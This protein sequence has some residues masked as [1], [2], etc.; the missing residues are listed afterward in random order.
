MHRRGLAPPY[1][2]AALH[3][4]LLPIA[5]NG[6]AEPIAP[7]PAIV[8][9][10]Q[11]APLLRTRTLTG[12]RS[13]K[14]RQMRVKVPVSP[15]TISLEDRGGA[16]LQRLEVELSTGGAKKAIRFTG[17]PLLVQL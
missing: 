4:A 5:G 9:K 17:A 12:A 10:P 8:A 14:W 1:N 3:V 6:T 11:S 15:L 2:T 7:D 13:L 16:S